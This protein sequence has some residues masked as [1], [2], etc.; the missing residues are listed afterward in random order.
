[1]KNNKMIKY[2]TLL[3]KSFSKLFINSFNYVINY[4]S[5]IYRY[6]LNLFKVT[7]ALIKESVTERKYDSTKTLCM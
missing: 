1:M 5:F 4:L 2:A 7:N 6:L 3:K